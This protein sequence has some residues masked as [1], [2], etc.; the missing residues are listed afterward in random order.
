M[1]ARQSIKLG[2]GS[3]VKFPHE[4]TWNNVTL[5]TMAW[6]ILCGD[7]PDLTVV[8]IYFP[9]DEQIQI[10]Q[11]RVIPCPADFP[12]GYYWYGRKRHSP[13]R[14]AQWLETLADV[15]E[16]DDT[17]HLGAKESQEQSELESGAESEAESE[18]ISD[19]EAT[20]THT[21]PEPE[22]NR[23]QSNRYTLRSRVK[24]PAR[25]MDLSSGRASSKG[26]VM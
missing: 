15:L 20:H 16:T 19:E 10:H 22:S 13:G 23:A 26:G 5:P 14:P 2:I 21:V 9:Q 24:P 25:L 3:L 12:A 6:T 18:A 1:Q 17:N 7:D 11:T 4:E 8:K